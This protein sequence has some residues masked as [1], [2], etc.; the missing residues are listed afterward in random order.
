MYKNDKLRGKKRHKQL[1][2]FTIIIETVMLQ[3]NKLHHLPVL[4]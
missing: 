2:S 3:L 1:T 4:F